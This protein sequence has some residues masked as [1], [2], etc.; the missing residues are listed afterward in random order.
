MNTYTG[1]LFDIYAHPEQGIVFWLL[2][3]DEKPHHFFDPDFQVTFYAGG[4][5]KRLRELW[6]FLKNRDVKLEYTRREDL[7][8]GPQ[9]VV[10][11]RVPGPASYP[12]FFKEVSGRFPD[13]I[14]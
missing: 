5:V 9:D 1:W 7:F 10:E 8:D 13:L 11:I 6:R 14:Y 12:A 3:E 2:G 4:A